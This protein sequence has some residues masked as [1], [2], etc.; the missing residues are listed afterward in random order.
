[1]AIA[2]RNNLASDAAIYTAANLLGALVP[3]L[4]LPIL[5]SVLSPHDY[6]IVA[7]F[8]VAISVLSVF[9][10]LSVQGS[11]SV[12]FYKL[13]RIEFAR[14]VTA[15]L[16]ILIA[17][18]GVIA[19][20]SLLLGGA[21]ENATGIPAGLLGVACLVATVQFV[22]AIRL[23]IWQNERSPLKYAAMQFAQVI[24]NAGLTLWLI[25]QVGFGWEGR[26]LGISVAALTM[27]A[28]SV[29]GLW[30]R[31]F[32]AVRTRKRYIE[33][34]LKFG[35]PLLPH[36]L[37]GMFIYSADQIMVAHLLGTAQAGVFSVA[38]SVASAIQLICMASS[39]AF[40]PWLYKHL[41]SMGEDMKVKVVRYIY[42][43]FILI[44]LLALAYGMAAPLLLEI[45]V[46]QE[47]IVDNFVILFVSLGFAFGGM[48]FAVANFVFQASA[49]GK[50]AVV[51]F[52]TG[53]IN[54]VLTYF[55]IRKFGLA[56]A[57]FGFMLTQAMFF[58]ATWRLSHL[59][60][61]MP[62]FRRQY[63]D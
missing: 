25:L 15:C 40:A 8:G 2:W 11:I 63:A 28:Y 38:L 54:L 14:F 13:D 41:P 24:L 32:I 19:F 36:V 62:W 5:T 33:D 10:G 23:S 42:G 9:I 59:V 58:I 61:P 29:I 53:S 44:S 48:Y 60:S 50:L 45:L 27:A 37:G 18:A 31:G 39:R 6:G 35:V 17:T 16:F 55:F 26:I 57:G 34:A 52:T 30:R 3:L 20:M 51:T 1:M 21:I 49:T 46:R 4:L 12:Q 47:F 22:T 56:G 7:L 43:Y